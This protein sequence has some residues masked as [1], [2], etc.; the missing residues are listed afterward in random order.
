MQSQKFAIIT[1]ITALL[2]L[3][4]AVSMIAPENAFAYQDQ[5]TS[6]TGVCGNEF[7]PINIGCQSTD[8]EIQL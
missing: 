2:L 3:V 7:I 6:Q 5:A 1:T 4:S 8:S